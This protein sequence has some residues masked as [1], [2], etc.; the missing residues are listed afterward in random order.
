MRRKQGGF[1]LMEAMAVA[2]IL[3][4]V[5]LTAFPLVRSVVREQKEM[6]LRLAL[7]K[8]R[9][10]IDEYKRYCDAGLLGELEIGS[11]CYPVDLE[12]LL[13]PVQLVGQPPE[14]Q[15]RFLNRIPVD[16]MTSEADW[17]LRSYEDDPDSDY[18]G[19]EDV[20]DVF[21]SS[22]RTGLNG[23]PYSEW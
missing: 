13:E 20:Y 2:A 17:G 15:V 11:R 9:H 14:S 18:W 23:V 6:Q 5:T 21:S 22:D 7:D 1:T 8:L 19:G 12:T 10:A 4:I 16:P 3:G